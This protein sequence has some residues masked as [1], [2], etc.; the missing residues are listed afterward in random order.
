MVS[1]LV[2]E[3]MVIDSSREVKFLGIILDESLSFSSQ[4]NYVCNRAKK[5]LDILRFVAAELETAEQPTLPTGPPNASSSLTLEHRAA[6][7][8][9]LD[10]PT[11]SGEYEDWENFCDLFTTLVHNAPGLADATRLQYLKTCLKGAAADLVKDVT[12]TNAN[13]SATWQDL[14][15]HFHNPRLI[16]YKHLRALLDM[17]HLK[18]ESA[19][20]LRSFADEA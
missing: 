12:T 11:F 10:L 4:V 15:A 17:P 13:Y 1:S 20:E 7:L 16:V 19:T 8:P 3:D 9:R 5:R 2:I 14:K 6:K 18:R